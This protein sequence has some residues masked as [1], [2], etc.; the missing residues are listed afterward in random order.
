MLMVL[1]MALTLMNVAP[2]AAASS[3]YYATFEDEVVR[4]SST[5][6][7]ANIL[8]PKYNK[9]GVGFCDTYWA[10]VFIS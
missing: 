2:F 6:H 1:A 9:A 7:R 5:G 8:S 10:Q 3:S 4:L